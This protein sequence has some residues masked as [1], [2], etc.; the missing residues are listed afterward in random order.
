[1][2]HLFK[3]LVTAFG[4]MA[5][6][7]GP[8]SAA[9]IQTPARVRLTIGVGGKSL[10]YYLPLT[11]AERKGFF[12]D[13][14]LDVQIIDFEG[15]AKALQAM[16]GGSLDIVSGAYEHTI[17]MQAR[18]WP[19][20]AIVLQDR[21][22]G[23]VLGI[24][25]SKAA[26]YSSPR[27]LK[28]WK[29]GVTSPGSSTHMALNNLL[30]KNG[31]NPK[32]VPVIGLGSSAGAVAAVKN[33][34]VD[35]IVNLDPVVSKLEA[36]G[37]ITAV[38]DT[39]TGKGMLEVYGGEYHAGCLYTP[40]AWVKKHPHAAQGV[41]NGIVRALLWLPSASIADIVAAVPLDYYGSDLDVYK[42]ALQ[43]NRE[44]FSP[45]GRFTLQG[46]KNV[47]RVLQQFVPE[48]QKARI[49][50]AETFDNRFVETALKKYG[51]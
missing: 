17:N 4:V 9:T 27:D 50:L 10:F 14:G 2:K 44:G 15:G 7:G 8:V 31:L 20:V 38:V 39:R 48:V 26:E 1:M 40:P 3:V 16:L 18:G 23:I 35:A 43:K 34:L 36:D 24:R 41:V 19:V 37:D 30:A 46:A 51:K 21:Y 11:I 49:N 5:A 33:S 29:I 42:A 13:E 28:G 12:R 32:D 47:H 6:L 45:D 22:N 25:K